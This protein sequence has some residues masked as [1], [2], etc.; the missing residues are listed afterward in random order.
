MN[1][2]TRA[3]AFTFVALAGVLATGCSNSCDELEDKYNDCCAR[4]P[5][6]ISC[7][8]TVSDDADSDFCDALLDSY[9]CAY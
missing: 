3:L 2:K 6:G 4:A 9:Q 5:A 7:S 1:L 8:V